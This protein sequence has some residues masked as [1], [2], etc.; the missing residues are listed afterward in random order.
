MQIRATRLTAISQ[1]VRQA[2][3]AFTP[4]L[5]FAANEPGVWYDP[6]DMST[7]FQDAAGTTPV[8][9]VE[10]PVGLMLDKSKGLVLGP[11][12]VTNGDF[13]TDT[14]WT[15]ETGWSI[16]GGTAVASGVNSFVAIYQSASIVVGRMYLVTFTVSNYSAGQVYAYAGSGGFGVA[17]SANGTY[18]QYIF[19]SGIAQILSK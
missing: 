2:Y 6:S 12:L 10:Q 1:A 17:R 16:S 4:S 8:T 11:E 9:A 3:G 14:A 5:L 15:K 7:M 19:A 18:T 13:S